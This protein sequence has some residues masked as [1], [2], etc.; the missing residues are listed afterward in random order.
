MTDVKPFLPALAAC[1]DP[2]DPPARQHQ[3]GVKGAFT[4]RARR[5][6]R[7]EN[8]TIEP[9]DYRQM[10]SRLI[11][12][13]ARRVADADMEDLADMLSLRT[14]LDAEIALVVRTGRARHGRSWADIGRA[15]GTTREAAFQ[16]WGAARE[17]A[18]DDAG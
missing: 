2:Y 8:R 13:Y 7:R 5:A 18:T 11:R 9:P 1:G 3:N 12:A 14:E 17:G 15:A 10:L 6:R 16:R 4:D